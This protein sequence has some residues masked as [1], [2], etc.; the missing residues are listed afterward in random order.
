VGER[1]QDRERFKSFA[2]WQIVAGAFALGI[3]LVLGTN[4]AD[5]ER[6]TMR[7]PAVMGGVG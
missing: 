5:V 7:V 2:K 6:R 1:L 4:L 3:A